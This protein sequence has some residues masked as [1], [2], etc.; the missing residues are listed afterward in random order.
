MFTL[1]TNQ[2]LDLYHFD[3]TRHVLPLPPGRRRP[4]LTEE[5]LLPISPVETVSGLRRREFTRIDIG[6]IL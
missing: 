4:E 2:P 5:V 1:P 3:H 6:R